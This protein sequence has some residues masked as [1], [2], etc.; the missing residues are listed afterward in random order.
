MGTF[1][2]IDET[3]MKMNRCL[4]SAVLGERDS[5]FISLPLLQYLTRLNQVDTFQH[6]KALFALDLGKCLRSIASSYEGR[7]YSKNI[8]YQCPSSWAQFN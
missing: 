8:C 7:G 5:D 6:L 3:I 4:R 2:E 1:D